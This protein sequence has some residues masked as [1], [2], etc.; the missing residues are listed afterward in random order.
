MRVAVWTGSPGALDLMEIGTPDPGPGEAVLR[1]RLCTVCASDRHTF[2]GRRQGPAPA[3]LGHEIVGEVA[4]VG[5]GAAPKALGGHTVAEGDRV[6]LGLLV[7][8]GAC[9]FCARHLPQKCERLFK[10]GHERLDAARGAEGG[11]AEEVLVR[12]GS[13]LAHLH[14]DVSDAAAAPAGC[15]GATAACAV[16]RARPFAGEVAV[17]TGCGMLGLWTTALLARIG[18]EVLAVDPDP[19]R[20]EAA[21]RMGA[22]VCADGADPAAAGEFVRDA[23]EGRGADLTIETS[24]HGAAVERCLA[25]LRTG[26][27]AVLVGSV[28]GAQPVPLDPSAVVRGTYRIEGVHNYARRDLRAALDLLGEPATRDTLAALVAPALPLERAGEVLADPAPGGPP[29]LAISP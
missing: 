7:S 8:C 9:F 14:P 11:L 25:D 6:L 22:V 12:S 23:T 16:R 5:P 21:R 4:S 20:L 17:V 1:V 18:V 19:A 28:H 29:R 27:R 13:A 24:G 15:A 2:H 10:Y 3:V 26:G